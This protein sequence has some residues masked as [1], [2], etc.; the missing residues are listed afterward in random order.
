MSRHH[1]FALL[2][3]L[4]AACLQAIEPLLLDFGPDDMPAAPGWQRLG[5]RTLYQPGQRSV[6][7]EAP[8]GSAFGDESTGE[9]RDSMIGASHPAAEAVLLADLANGA[10]SVTVQVGCPRPTE[11]RTHQCVDINGKPLI[12]PPG[13]GAWGKMFTRRLPAIVNDGRLRIRFHTDGDSG[14]ARVCLVSTAIR[15]AADAAEA[16]AIAA[17]WEA[18]GTVA[19]APRLVRL[20][21]RDVPVL[22]VV[23]PGTLRQ[24]AAPPGGMLFFSKADSG[25]ILSQTRPDDADVTAK[26]CAFAAQDEQQHLLFGLHACQDLG[27]VTLELTPLRHADGH[28]IPADCLELRI[29]TSLYRSVSDSTANAEARLA[30]ELL[31]PYA[32]FRLKRH[33]TQPLYLL[34]SQPPDL[35]AGL[36]RGEL[37]ASAT[38]GRSASLAIVLQVLPFRLD[39]PPPERDWLLCVDTPWQARP[40]EW[41]QAQIRDF[42][43][44][45]ITGIMYAPPP[46][47]GHFQET[48]QGEITAVDFTPE[49]A[50]HFRYAARIGID[51]TL[52]ISGTP[53]LKWWLS[54]WS[55]P[56]Q[57]TLTKQI[58]EADGRKW[59]SLRKPAGSGRE[60]V[61]AAGFYGIPTGQ[62]VELAVTYRLDGAASAALT[63]QFNDVRRQKTQEPVTLALPASPAFQTVAI[64]FATEADTVQYRA[65]FSLDGS[66]TFTLD[67]LRLA[68]LSQPAANYFVNPYWVRKM[69]SDFDVATF[70]PEDY[71][72]SYRQYCAALKRAADSL[73]FR[74]VSISGTDEAGGSPLHEYCETSELRHARAAGLHTFCN[75]SIPLAMKI[76]DLLDAPC[77]YADLFGSRANEKKI[78][79]HFSALGKKVYHV[80][81]G[82][83]AG[84]NFH[85]S[86]NRFNVGFHFWQSSVE[87]SWIW[88]LQRWQGDPYDDFDANTKDYLM[89]APPR[90]TGE[91]DLPTVS[92]EGIREGRRDFDY[93]QT[94]SNSI[95]ACPDAERARRG[96]AI[97]AFIESS[98]PWYDA[99]DPQRHNDHFFDDLRYL[100]ATAILELRGLQ[101]T[102]TTPPP[103]Q[104][105]LEITPAEAVEPR[106]SPAVIPFSAAPPA[107]DGA[108]SA[109]FLQQALRLDDFRLHLH[110]QR[111]GEHP[112]EAYLLHDAGALYVGLRCYGPMERLK[113]GAASEAAVFADDSVEILLNPGNPG[114]AGYYQFA[115]NA[116]GTK[117]ALACVGGRVSS[118]FAVNY[119]E[120][121]RDLDWNCDWQVRT[122]RLD[123][124]WEALATIP[125]QALNRRH[126][127]WGVLIGR[128][129]RAAGETVSLPAIGFF[130][131]PEKYLPAA[132]S[133][134]QFSQW[135]LPHLWSGNYAAPAQGRISVRGADQNQRT[136]DGTYTLRPGDQE[137]VLS[138]P[139]ATY[140]QPL[141]V[142]PR[143]QLSA[144][145]QVF[146]AGSGPGVAR[147]EL[148]LGATDAEAAPEVD[149]TL[150]MGST[151]LATRRVQL[152]GR[153]GTITLPTAALPP[154]FYTLTAT[155]A[156]AGSGADT[157]ASASLPLIIAPGF[158][159]L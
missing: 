22:D 36:Y 147:L 95:T 158:R 144:P 14:N 114:A 96:A 77:F 130:D 29:V 48:P 78:V 108:L 81:A 25:A 125:L 62:E 82:A 67:Q 121:K 21:Q 35:P 39:P 133:F 72:A 8:W 38:D 118:I 19:A 107:W 1:I 104:L 140:I 33:E 2:L 109:S 26:L 17:E 73:G 92:W 116:E 148:A 127:L 51:R 69:N 31:E 112:T 103:R 46:L 42:K 54:Q 146:T 86:V 99:F 123:D 93:L 142:P 87:G 111:R 88:T 71:V 134:G 120:H 105:P 97:L 145:R 80:T 157:D 57:S 63:L 122:A 32:P 45:G 16:S 30:G 136:G 143:L 41:V 66:G 58:S 52:N 131:Q 64:R 49:L 44:H 59:C 37:R 9:P 34:I 56:P 98:L 132:L 84:Q 60:S 6:G 156:T 106:F 20:G 139:Q 101:T 75:L 23:R 137:I 28:L 4:A 13:I 100:A 154:G 135:P 5:P 153:A 76:P 90:Q 113:S 129:H 83:Y 15:P 85:L 11:G 10:Y 117:A 155:L 102:A 24:F 94:L 89:L 152:P 47:T 128:N 55:L 50:E 115:F 79:G 138:T 150:A 91:P 159:D 40:P 43:R 126:D 70:W 110:P 68:P 53:A 65:E 141:Q 27:P 151:L 149:V 74:Q 3:M 12:P 61:T 18:A 124:R 119:A 7:W